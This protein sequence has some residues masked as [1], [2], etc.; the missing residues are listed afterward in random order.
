MRI[1]NFAPALF[2]G[3]LC[4]AQQ[5]TWQT[6][7]ELPGVDWHGISG[8]RKDAALKF[9]REE[10]CTCGCNMKIAECR[11]KDPSCSYSRKEASIAMK[12]F[13]EGKNAATVR[14]EIKK[15]AG[16]PPPILED[17]V[18]I[19]L[20]GDPAKGPEN[21]KVTIV[22]FSDFQCPFC[23][24]AVA[25]ANAIVKQFPRDV[26]LVFKQFPLDSHRDA[27]FGAEA[28]LAAQAQGKFWE[29]HDLLYGGFPDLSRRTVM[30][31]GRKLG[32]D[33]NRFTSD[34]DSHKFQS[35]V[36]SEEQ[37]GEVAGVGGTP[38]FF[39]NGRKYNGVFDVASVAPL[40][41]KQLKP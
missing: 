17:P 21:A 14:D 40:I 18:K 22:E 10:Q 9:I 2:L 8:A 4:L 26:R 5:G 29:M 28:A 41:K 11:M 25:Q 13:A 15:A 24:V 23:S 1:R 27:E 39:I 37:E 6:A 20:N 7:T 38:T 16:E 19:S 33:M 34:V 32:L 36:H 3:A 31:Y 30:N 12:G 35:R